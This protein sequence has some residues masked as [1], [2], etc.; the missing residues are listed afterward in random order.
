MNKCIQIIIVFLETAEQLK[1]LGVEEKKINSIL[2]QN[3]DN[4]WQSFKNIN[5]IPKT[6]Y[7][8]KSALLK[9]ERLENQGKRTDKSGRHFVREHVVPKAIHL[10][11]LRSIYEKRKSTDNLSSTELINE[12]REYMELN[13][14]ICAITAS[15]NKRFKKG[16][17]ENKINKSL[18]H[19]MPDN[20]DPKDGP[21]VR[22]DAVGIEWDDLTNT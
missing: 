6:I 15:E 7:W 10:K 17:R 3:I 14:I 16:H 18:E 5:S 8:S 4:A 21:W 20:W 11:Q 2:K 12:I 22:Y 1:A 19:Q 9:K 13:Y